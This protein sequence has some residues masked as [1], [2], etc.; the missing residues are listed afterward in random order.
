M[1]SCSIRRAAQIAAFACTFGIASSVGAQALP[2]AFPAPS[3][4][5]DTP[6][7]PSV[8]DLVVG[9]GGLRISVTSSVPGLTLHGAPA[10][11]RFARI[12]SDHCE[13]RAVP[14]N[15][16][17]VIEDPSGRF[18][19]VR[20]SQLL[21]RNGQLEIS[22]R[23]RQPH[24]TAL[25]TIGILLTLVSIAPLVVAKTNCDDGDCS[26]SGAMVA[27]GSGLL[28]GGLVLLGVSVTLR[29]AGH[30]VFTPSQ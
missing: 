24:R 23:S 19:Y 16:R 4:A 18:G 2:P 15:Y 12:C 30:L 17:F 28:L 21:D 6:S 13:L 25:R 26:G 3:S 8:P 7:T 20:G 22:M 5:T 27:S 14:G 1:S 9:D 10:G 29:D 11:T